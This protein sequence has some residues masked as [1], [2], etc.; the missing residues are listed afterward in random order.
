MIECKDSLEFLKEQDEYSANIIY[1]DPPYA[2]GSE[3]IIRPDGKVDYKTDTFWHLLNV[4]I[5]LWNNAKFHRI[6]LLIAI[7]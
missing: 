1:S 7:L 3:V 5:V 2:L 6:N 4:I